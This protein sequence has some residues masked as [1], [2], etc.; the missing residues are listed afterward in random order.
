MV[1][2]KQKVES[3]ETKKLGETVFLGYTQFVSS[4]VSEVSELSD[5]L[6]LPQSIAFVLVTPVPRL[7][8]LTG[9]LSLSLI[10]HDRGKLLASG[11][12]RTSSRVTSS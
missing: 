6:L 10:E 3:V 12:E 2:L 1:S 11:T 8:S 4:P 7:L 9:L 5:F